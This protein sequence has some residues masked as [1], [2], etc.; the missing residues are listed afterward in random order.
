MDVTSH[1]VRELIFNAWANRTT[2][3]GVR[4]AR[5]LPARA[6]EIMAHIT[7]AEW[8]WL[9]RLGEPGPELAVWPVL[10]PADMEQQLHALASAWQLACAELDPEDL[11]RVVTYTNTKGEPWTNRVSDI[12]THVVLHSSYHRGQVAHLLAQSGEAPPYADYIE[13]VRRGH[14]DLGWPSDGE[15]PPEPPPDRGPSG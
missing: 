15:S 8:L 9:R 3:E 14:L 13:A 5:N 7:G 1:H 6:G 11:D 10:S 4:R 2:L 12:L